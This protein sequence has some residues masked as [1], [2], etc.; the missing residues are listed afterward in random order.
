[1]PKEAFGGEDSGGGKTPDKRK[2]GLEKFG[3][4]PDANI[5]DTFWRIIG[6]YA[7]TRKPGV[8]LQGL[9]H[10]RFALMRVALSV[11]LSSASENYGLPPKFIAEY[12]LMMMIDGGWNDALTEFMEKAYEKRFSARKEVSSAVKKLLGHEKY[13]QA[14]VERFGAMVRRRE[15]GSIAL[16]Y[17]AEADSV[18]LVR[19][20]KKE[21][22]IIA[23]GDIGENQMNAIKA[24]ALL[25][26]D[27]EVKKS[28]IVLLSHWDAQ[29]RL[30]AAE[31]LVGMS[32][33]ENV[34]TAAGKR[35]ASETN[36]EIRKVLK[37]IIGE[38]EGTSP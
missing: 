18:A 9:E 6:S 17:I 38:E 31:V 21:L 22:I 23:R 29:A 25:K 20:L 35:L 8:E 19:A 4:S 5:R 16:H 15:T 37:K 36:E 12:A 10:D 2:L 33:D 26:D 24:I 14:L 30:A 32:G 11:L 13:G 3:L 1:M 28:L 34:K 7:A 27:E